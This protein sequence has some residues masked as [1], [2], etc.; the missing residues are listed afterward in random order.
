[1]KK[2]SIALV[3]CLILMFTIAVPTFAAEAESEERVPGLVSEKVVYDDAGNPIIISLY[4]LDE[5]G[6]LPFPEP[7]YTTIYNG[8]TVLD[9]LGY[10]TLVSNYYTSSTFNEAITCYN[11]GN[12]DRAGA[13][14]FL[15][16]RSTEAIQ[17]VDAGQAVI[18]TIPT[19]GENLKIEILAKANW[20]TDEYN[21]KITAE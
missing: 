19:G 13:L 21:I 17:A 12:K 7:R 18:F 8:S 15:V 4:N 20:Y 6:N 16:T 9:T 3:L 1:M 14:T 10:S 2:R 11:Y 5:N